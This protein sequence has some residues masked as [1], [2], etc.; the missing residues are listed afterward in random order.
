LGMILA[1]RGDLAGAARLF[2]AALE[3]DPANG[4]TKA[5]LQRALRHLKLVQ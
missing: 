4:D 1:I 2:A 3:I 5:N